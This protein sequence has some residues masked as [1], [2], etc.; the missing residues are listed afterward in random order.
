MFF[1]LVSFICFGG[2]IS[3]LVKDETLGGKC[4]LVGVNGLLSATGFSRFSLFQDVDYVG[5]PPPP[6]LCFLLLGNPPPPQ[7][8]FRLT[9]TRASLLLCQLLQA[10]FF[11]FFS[12][13]FF[14]FLLL[15]P[16]SYISLRILSCNYTIPRN[17]FYP[18]SRFLPIFPG[19]LFFFPFLYL[20]LCI[21]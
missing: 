6:W 21:C 9:R 16:I 17:H 12:I 19:T 11:F 2:D 1:S 14:F 15:L 7:G 20:M 13:V 5:T 18:H 3:L 10:V 4:R 8:E